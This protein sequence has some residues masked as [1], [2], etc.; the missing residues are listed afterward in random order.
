M[1]V[2]PRVRS[3]WAKIQPKPRSW[4][5]WWNDGGRRLVQLFLIKK[6]DTENTV[7]V[8]HRHRRPLRVQG[9]FDAN[10]LSVRGIQRRHIRKG[11]VA[12]DLLLQRQLRCRQ[13]R[14]VGKRRIDFKLTHSE[15]PL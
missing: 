4:Q 7:L 6:V 10:G 3:G 5:K 8:S 9:P 1:T 14:S 13:R 15:H 2:P 11:Q 12:G